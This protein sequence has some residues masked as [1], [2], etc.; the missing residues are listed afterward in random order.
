M[1][2]SDNISEVIDKNRSYLVDHIAV[3]NNLLWEKL[4]EYGLFKAFD[5]Q[6]IK[7]SVSCNPYF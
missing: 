2:M 6:Q 3:K 7:V 5:V 4:T 1:K